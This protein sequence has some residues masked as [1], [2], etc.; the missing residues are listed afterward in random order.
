MPDRTRRALLHLSGTFFIGVLAG[1]ING[2]VF[3]SDSS[4]V[5]SASGNTEQSRDSRSPAS[6]SASSNAECDVSNFSFYGLNNQNTDAMW[7]PATASVSYNFGANQTT[8]IVVLEGDE[9]LGTKETSSPEDTPIVVDGDIVHLDRKLSGI[10]TIRAVMYANLGGSDQL[11]PDQATPC[12]N[13]GEIIQ[14][15]ERTVTFSEF[16]SNPT[17]T[18]R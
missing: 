7:G 18:T 5:N 13:K 11:T 9:V 16:T 10:H 17:T 2:S 1:C 8:Y 4:S 14:T 12:R 15:E 3:T 6:T